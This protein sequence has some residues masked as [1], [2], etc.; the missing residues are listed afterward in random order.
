VPARQEAHG[1]V[2]VVGAASGRIL[3]VDWGERRLGLAVSDPTRTIAQPA[4]A[5]TVS[6]AKA[7]L[8]GVSTA[9]RQWEASVLLVGLPLLMDGTMGEAARKAQAFARALER[10]SGLPV[11]TL[12]ERL[13]TVQAERLQREGRRPRSAE[14]GRKAR[15]RGDADVSAAVVLLQ[16]YLDRQGRPEPPGSGS[17]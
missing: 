13:T 3:A 4:G 10:E 12:D 16:S 6:G 11:V 14:A 17:A 8:Q 5:I 9:A 15:R 2:R 7:A 1:G